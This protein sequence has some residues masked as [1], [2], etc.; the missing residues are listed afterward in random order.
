MIYLVALLAEA[1]TGAGVVGFLAWLEGGK[2][3]H[4]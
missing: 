1:L 4:R 2:G 3:E